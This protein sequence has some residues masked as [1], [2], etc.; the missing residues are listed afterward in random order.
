MKLERIQILS[1]VL[2]L[3][4]FL[5]LFEIAYHGFVQ[6]D[7]NKAQIILTF[8]LL[9][10]SAGFL[11]GYQVIEKKLGR[12]DLV[13]M[14]SF[15][16]L[17]VLLLFSIFYTRNSGTIMPLVL[18]A[19]YFLAAIYLMVKKDFLS[20]LTK[21][22]NPMVRF[23]S[24]FFIVL[25]ILILPAAGYEYG[26]TGAVNF[27]FDALYMPLIGLITVLT[28]WIV[29]ALG[30]SVSAVAQKGGYDLVAASGF[31]VF[32]GAFCS[33][34][35]SMSVFIAAFFAISGDLK[36]EKKRKIALFAAGILG[37]F[38]ANIIRVVIL[39]MVG[40]Y[41]GADALLTVHTHLGWIIFFIWISVFWMVALKYTDIKKEGYAYK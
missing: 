29:G 16:G 36:M 22:E 31:K 15:L 8:L 4:A 32:V 13:E 5:Y 37:T 25:G 33:G 14:F 40:Y 3:G 27:K 7:F 41:Y 23:S 2:L 30:V 19:A 35:T 11:I 20:K 1:I 6:E 21:S 39:F 17:T 10:V 26:M 18:A 24:K 34:V 9:A 28:K 38:F 12:K